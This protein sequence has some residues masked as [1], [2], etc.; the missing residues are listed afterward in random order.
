MENKKPLMVE[1]SKKDLDHLV[2]LAAKRMT[3]YTLRDILECTVHTSLKN[4]AICKP[5]PD[6]KE[7][8]LVLSVPV[9]ERQDIAY[10]I[11]DIKQAIDTLE[12]HG[13]RI[14]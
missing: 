6:D 5:M 12:K 9:L 4:V 13:F 1:V 14:T 3:N 10:A 8:C 11:R 2:E 7:E